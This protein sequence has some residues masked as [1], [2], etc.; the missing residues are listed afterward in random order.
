[1]CGRIHLP[2]CLWVCRSVCHSV[3]PSVSLS[4]CLPALPLSVD[5]PV[6]L[7]LS[8]RLSDS[9]SFF[10]TF[11]DCFSVSISLE[12]PMSSLSHVFVLSTVGFLFICVSLLGCV[13]C[14][15]VF[16]GYPFSC[17]YACAYIFFRCVVVFVKLSLSMREPLQFVSLLFLELLSL[18][19]FSLLSLCWD[20]KQKCLSSFR[21]V[22]DCGRPA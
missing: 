12:L 11:C 9:Q 4:V 2:V 6:L 14:V 7:C 20:S 1:M 15:C 5:H 19:F 16:L 8:S 10:L 18:C 22:A 21:C 13:L 17:V 3:C